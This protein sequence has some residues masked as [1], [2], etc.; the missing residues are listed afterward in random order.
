[1]ATDGTSRAPSPKINVWAKTVVSLA[2]QQFSFARWLCCQCVFIQTFLCD[3]A[4]GK[5][6]LCGVAVYKNM[7]GQDKIRFGKEVID[8]IRYDLDACGICI[9]FGRNASHRCCIY[10][11][12]KKLRGLFRLVAE[13]LTAG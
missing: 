8:E 11:E 9:L 2:K 7:G 6:L 4:Q 13:D 12:N 10:E 1:M 5:L 3:T